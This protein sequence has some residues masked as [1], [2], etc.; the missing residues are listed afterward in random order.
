MIWRVLI[1]KKK[2]V[3]SSSLHTSALL[4]GDVKNADMNGKSRGRIFII[5]ER[6]CLGVLT[7]KVRRGEQGLRCSV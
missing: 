4:N 2:R 6:N 1:V 7:V 5:A 3:L